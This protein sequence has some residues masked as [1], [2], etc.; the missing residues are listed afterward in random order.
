M[1]GSVTPELVAPLSSEIQIPPVSVPA[2][3]HSSWT[4][5]AL[6]FIPVP[7]DSNESLPEDPESFNRNFDVARAIT[8][9]I[10]ARKLFLTFT[11][12]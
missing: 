10:Y 5:W 1:D 3:Q 4:S 9:G 12:T 2:K 7:S 6:S 11:V 8:F